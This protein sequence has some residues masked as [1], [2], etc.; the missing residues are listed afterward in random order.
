MV[1]QGTVG[2]AYFLVGIL[3]VS[4]ALSACDSGTEVPTEEL[5]PVMVEPTNLPSTEIEP[6]VEGEMEED[7]MSESASQTRF[8]I[9]SSAFAHETSIPVKYSC[10]GEN[11]SPPLAWTDPPGDTMSF[12]LINDD[13]DAPVGI[14]VHWVLYNIPAETRELGED[15][16][17]QDAFGDG[18]LHG[19]NSWGRRDYGGPCPPGGTHRYFFKLYALDTVLELGAGA[20]TQTLTAAMEGHILAV[21]ELMGTY[22]R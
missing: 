20:D 7:S 21:A 16:P 13:P 22:T 3:M 5:P 4:S 1:K 9:T 2:K 8:E 14:W 12:A 17:A 18:S 19:Q 10:D 6:S 11:V 15:I